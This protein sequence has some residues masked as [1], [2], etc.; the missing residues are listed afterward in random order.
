[1]IKRGSRGSGTVTN[2]DRIVHM[3]V[4]ADVKPPA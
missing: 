4:A 2:P 3:R 1:M